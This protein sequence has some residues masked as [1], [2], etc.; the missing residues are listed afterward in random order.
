[1]DIA[2]PC[3]SLRKISTSLRKISTYVPKG[4]K[5]LI[6]LIEVYIFI[7]APRELI[8]G[9]DENI[10]IY[11]YINNFILQIYWEI[12]VDVLTQNIGETEIDQNLLKC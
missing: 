10:C 4:T 8:G 12:M 9:K 5:T 6:S 7:G 2:T 3:T 11:R 1:M